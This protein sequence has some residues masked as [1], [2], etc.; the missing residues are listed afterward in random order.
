[1][2]AGICGTDQTFSIG[3]GESCIHEESVDILFENVDSF[4]HGFGAIPAF[5]MCLEFEENQL[6]PF[7]L[8]TI[9]SDTEKL[10]SFNSLEM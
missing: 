2:K 3:S 5:V 6:I 7:R 4:F 1:M 8:F 9:P 10:R